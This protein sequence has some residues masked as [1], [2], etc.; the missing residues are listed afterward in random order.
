METMKN[1]L[2]LKAQ[3][4]QSKIK[5]IFH[6]VILEDGKVGI[7]PDKEHPVSEAETIGAVILLSKQ[8]RA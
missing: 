6:V 5:G 7:Q 2:D 8:M 4:E 1:Q 3:Q